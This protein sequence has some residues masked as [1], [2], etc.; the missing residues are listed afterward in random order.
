MMYGFMVMAIAIG[1]VAIIAA[2]ITLADYLFGDDAVGVAVLV[3]FTLL[4]AWGT[5]GVIT[6]DN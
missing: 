5:G 3:I 1:V 4:F 2:A 6:D